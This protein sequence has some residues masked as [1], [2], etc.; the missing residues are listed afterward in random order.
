MTPPTIAPTLLG[1]EEDISGPEVDDVD[2][3][4]DDDDDDVDVV[5]DD[6]D[7]DISLV[8]CIDP[9]VFDS[10]INVVDGLE[11]DEES[12]EEAGRSEDKDAEVGRSEDKD[13]EAGVGVSVIVIREVAA[14]AG[15]ADVVGAALDVVVVATA[16]IWSVIGAFAQAIYE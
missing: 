3:V 10:D 7:D 1:P 5:E 15:V 14:G 2:V 16:I 6:D 12:D 9:D 8:N 4:E 13:T 11:P